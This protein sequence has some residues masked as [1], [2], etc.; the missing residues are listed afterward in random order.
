M[1]FK[2]TEHLTHPIRQ[3]FLQVHSLRGCDDV[4]NLIRGSM[5]LARKFAKSL[6][7]DCYRSKI[8]YE[9]PGTTFKFV[10]DCPEDDRICNCGNMHPLLPNDPELN[11]MAMDPVQ[12]DALFQTCTTQHLCNKLY[13]TFRNCDAVR[14]NPH[15]HV[16]LKQ[17]R[18][19]Q[20]GT[21]HP[22]QDWTTMHECPENPD[23]ETQLSPAEQ[24]ELSQLEKQR[25]ATTQSSNYKRILELFDRCNC[26]NFHHGVGITSSLKMKKQAALIMAT[27]LMPSASEMASASAAKRASEMASASASAAKRAANGGRRKSKRKMRRHRTRKCK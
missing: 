7:H 2:L 23:P 6:Q 19:E 5:P 8:L 26:G 3:K 21:L 9:I 27:A 16:W 20:L 12:L 22:G 10:K 1:N 11:A 25:I 4:Y 14:S 17:F 24:T 18:K 15:I 13:N